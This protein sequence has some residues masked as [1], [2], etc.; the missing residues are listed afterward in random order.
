M[1]HAAMNPTKNSS[2]PPVKKMKIHPCLLVVSFTA[3]T[4][5][6]HA[7]IHPIKIFSDLRCY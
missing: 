6:L 2:T 4:V 7:A 5:L 3:P 1:L